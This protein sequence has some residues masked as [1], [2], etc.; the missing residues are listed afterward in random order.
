MFSHGFLSRSEEGINRSLRSFTHLAVPCKC[1]RFL[2]AI[3]KLHVAES[4]DE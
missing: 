3:S 4:S 1:V 2:V